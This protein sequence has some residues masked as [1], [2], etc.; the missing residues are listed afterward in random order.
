LSF[1]CSKNK[2]IQ[3]EAYLPLPARIKFILSHPQLNTKFNCEKTSLVQ[4]GRLVLNTTEIKIC[5]EVLKLHNNGNM[6]AN[7]IAWAF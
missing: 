1:G 3:E 7:A 5:R 6:S 4:Q 2:Y